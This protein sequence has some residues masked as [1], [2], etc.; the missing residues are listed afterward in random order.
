MS[1]PI[2]VGIIRCDT[3]GAYYAPLMAAH[4]PYKL[5]SPIPPGEE[6][7][8]SWMTGGAH[9]YFY[10]NYANP[11]KISVETVDGFEVVNV[12]DENRRAAEVLSDV[13]DSHPRVCDSFEQVS[14]GVDLVFIGDCNGDG[15][16]HVLHSTPGLEKGIATYIDK[17]LANTVEDVKKIMALSAKHSAPVF[18]SSILRHVPGATQF[19]K[20]MD[21]IGGAN[22]GFIRGGGCHIAGQI[23]TASL[24]QAVFGNGISEVH[25]SGPGEMGIMHLSWGDRDDRPLRGVAIHHNTDEQWHCSIHV[26]AFGPD[27]GI[28]AHNNI[29]DYF[30]PYGA[31]N[32]LKHIKKMVL[33]G[34]VHDSMNDMIEAVAVINAGRLSYKEGGRAVKVAEVQ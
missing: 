16:D 24:A 25:A 14:E 11:E 20:R 22:S 34:E 19:S 28:L 10:H 8:Y 31:A 30:F 23:H 15:S 13:L 18:S 1:D 29:N 9:F 33:T 27:G 12:W 32:I 3:H 7:G 4:D 2:K 6:G 21:E 26:A 5:Q 17:P